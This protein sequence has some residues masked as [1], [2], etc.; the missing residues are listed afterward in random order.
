MA[1]KLY[2]D[3]VKVATSGPTIDGRVISAQDITDMAE[4]YDPAEYTANIWYEHIR[5]FGNLGKVVD[6]K[7]EKDSKGR[8]CLFA[9]LAPSD[10]LIYLNNNGQKLFTSIEIQPEFAG[11]GKAYLAGLAVTDSP[12]SLGTTELQFSRRLQS[13][14]NFFAEP[15]EL[16]SLELEQT[17]GLLGRLFE[18]FGN[19][20]DSKPKGDTPMDEKQFNALVGTLESMQTKLGELENKFAQQN[21]ADVDES[22]PVSKKEFQALVDKVSALDKKFAETDEGERTSEDK[23]DFSALSKQLEELTEKF[24]QALNTARPGTPVPE[25]SGDAGNAR[26]L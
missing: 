9:K 11:T 21:Q 22:A 1:R 24:N 14:E 25:G 26:V 3:W 10:E 13:P 4:S 6:L 2:T 20:P 23:T 17:P 19:S 16:T 8:M 7:A 5:I 12:A 15:V 18:H